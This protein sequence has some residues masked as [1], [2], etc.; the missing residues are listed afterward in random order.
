VY[1]L[2]SAIV[3]FCS[4]P[5]VSIFVWIKETLWQRHVEHKFY[6]NAHFKAL[7][8]AF[9]AFY[10][11]SSP[12]KIA[13]NFNRH[14]NHQNIY[15]FGSTPLHVY[16]QILYRWLNLEPGSFLEL[17]SGTGRGLL[18]LSIFYFFPLEGVEIN[19]TF[20]KT[21][22]DLINAFEL[23]NLKISKRDYLLMDRF[24]ADWIYLYEF[25]MTDEQ[26]ELI[27]EKL[28]KTSKDTTKIITVSFPLSEY[29]NKFMVKDSF[30]TTFP[31]G[32]AEVYLN[33]IKN[34]TI[35]N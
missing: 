26:L 22:Q 28:I 33:T 34:S 30:E 20:V 9:L 10:R 7:D 24:E 31:W 5:F 17:G 27:C 15:S 8:K 19:P 32:K 6:S 35:Q 16:A 2:V 21:T 11:K 4:L 13:A 29:H 23:S 12:Y 1:Q 25:F 14:H 18:F 3:D